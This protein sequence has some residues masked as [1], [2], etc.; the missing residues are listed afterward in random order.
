MVVM[1]S[2]SAS[3]LAARRRE[4]GH[5]P[6]HQ[7]AAAGGAIRNRGRENPAHQGPPGAGEGPDSRPPFA[8]SPSVWSVGRCASDVPWLA[9][10]SGL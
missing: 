3:W 6:E 10:T 4:G 1:N 5:E 2:I 8:A 7:P 9:K